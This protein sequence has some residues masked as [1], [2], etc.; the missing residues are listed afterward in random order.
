VGYICTP[1]VRSGSMLKIKTG[2]PDGAISLECIRIRLDKSKNFLCFRNNLEGST[3]TF[4]ARPTVFLV[5]DCC[6]QSWISRT[7]FSPQRMRLLLSFVLP[8]DRQV[9]IAHVCVCLVILTATSTNEEP[10]NKFVAPPPP[11]PVILD[12]D[13]EA[14]KCN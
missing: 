1:E 12:P 2:S 7:N 13:T 8:L 14:M 9:P 3:G 5:H 10:E 4:T 6:T 11:P